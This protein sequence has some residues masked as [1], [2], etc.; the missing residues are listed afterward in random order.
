MK[1]LAAAQPLVALLLAQSGAAPPADPPAAITTL[2]PPSAATT[3]GAKIAMTGEGFTPY[4]K[5]YFDGM[6]ARESKFVSDFQIDAVTPFLRPGEHRL[7]IKNPNG[8]VEASVRFIAAATPIDAVLDAAL[9]QAA[10]G[11]TS[12]AMDTLRHIAETFNDYQVR[13]YAYYEM[14]RISLASGDLPGWCVES[15]DIFLDANESGNS[16]QTYWPYPLADY[17]SGDVCLLGNTSL[18]DEGF[19]NVIDKDVT[20]AP[21]PRFERGLFDTRVGKIKKARQDVNFILEKE[22]SNAAYL[23]LSALVAEA[24]GNR[25]LARRREEAAQSALPGSGQIATSALAILGELEY[26]MGDSRKAQAFWLRMGANSPPSA[27]IA[28]SRAKRYLNAGDKKNG[29]M[30]LSEASAAAPNTAAAA[31]ADKMKHSLETPP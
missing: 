14:S 21:E 7:W 28:L 11:K 6:E 9:A 26:R 1:I 17:V 27:L 4:T 20:G 24:E 22:P 10:S 23:A 2:S 25:T 15:A 31:E 3:P 30:F 19:D 8:I 18:S 5:I 16:I 13:A 12:A 29:A